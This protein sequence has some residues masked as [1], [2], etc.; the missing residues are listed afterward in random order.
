MTE[1][2]GF[3]ADGGVG[4]AVGYGIVAVALIAIGRFMAQGD[5]RERRAAGVLFAVA[6]GHVAAAGFALTAAFN[7]DL[8]VAGVLVA[9]WA[10]VVAV[11]LR[12][13]LPALTTQF[14]LLASLTGLAAA[15]L[16]LIETGWS[17]TR[18]SRTP[19]RSSRTA[20]RARCSS[21]SPRRRGGSP[22]RR[23]SA[24]SG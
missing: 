1:S 22:S 11:G 23:S 3:D 2:A 13:Y 8:Q 24:S 16:S 5:A 9:A 14:T 21:S 17:P 19:V 18:S 7:L 15:L 10:A 20:G 6:V 4:L 12:L